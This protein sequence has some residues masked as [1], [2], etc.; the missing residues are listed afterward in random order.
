MILIDIIAYSFINK[1]VGD[2]LMLEYK[3]FNFK[4]V[5][6]CCMCCDTCTI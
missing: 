3:L 6:Q 2:I 5:L 1:G 4:R